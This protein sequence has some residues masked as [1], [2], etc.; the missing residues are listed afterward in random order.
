MPP[1]RII[2]NIILYHFILLCITDNTIPIATLPQPLIER[3]RIMLL[4][5]FY[6]GVGCHC[7]KPSHYICYRCPIIHFQQQAMKMIGHHN[8]YTTFY[9]VKLMF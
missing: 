4:H 9:I 5:T 7:F 3:L 8:R 6:I 1:S 2:K